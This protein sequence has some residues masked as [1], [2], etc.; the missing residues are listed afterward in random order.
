[1]KQ[2]QTKDKH[3]STSRK[4]IAVSTPEGEK[5]GQG[6]LLGRANE[7]PLLGSVYSEAQE[8]WST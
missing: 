5:V 4:A 6:K 8:K 3:K 7:S 1:M 2:H